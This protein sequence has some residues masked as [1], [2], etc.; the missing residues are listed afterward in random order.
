MFPLMVLLTAFS[1]PEFQAP[2]PARDVLPLSVLPDKVSVPLLR[3]PPP[4][5]LVA[6]LA[7]MVLLV[8]SATPEPP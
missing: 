4:V 2:P 5:K 6:V 7:L 1:A 8:T 3:I